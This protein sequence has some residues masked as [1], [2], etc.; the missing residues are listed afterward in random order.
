[1][2]W[3][4]GGGE[5]WGDEEWGNEDLGG[6]DWKGGGSGCVCDSELSFSHSGG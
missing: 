3:F 6:V 5:I 4:L 2:F 1:M